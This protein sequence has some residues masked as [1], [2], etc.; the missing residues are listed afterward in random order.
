MKQVR[1]GFFAV[2]FCAGFVNAMSL[3][4]A[5]RLSLE[6]N[7]KT[8][9]NQLRVEAMQ[10][11][12]KAQWAS[13]YPALRLSSSVDMSNMDGLTTTS[14]GISVG[15]SVTI[16]NGGADKYEQKSLQA[17]L[18]AT[19]AR[20][21][22]S[23]ASMPN[24]KGSIAKNVKDAYVSLVDVI[25]QKK[26]L[27]ILS[28]TLQ[29][30][31]SAKPSDDEKLLIQQRLN[32]LN[33]SLIRTQA[34][35]ESALRDFR[36]FA[37]VP[38]P[39]LNQLDSYDQVTDSLDIPNS[40]DEAFQMALQ[41]SP[42]LK[43]AAYE[44]EAA[45]YDYKAE[46]ARLYAPKV[47]ANASIQRGTSVTNGFSSSVRTNSIGLSASF[48][49]SGASHYQDSAAAKNVAAS[50]RDR[51]GAIDELK[52]KIESIYPSL[53]TQEKLYE[54]QLQNLKSAQV[55]M[56]DIVRK[57][58][59]GQKVDLKTAMSVLDSQSQYW[60]SCVMQKKSILDTRFNIQRTIGTLFESLGL[61]K[62]A[63]TSIR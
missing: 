35:L 38:A 17:S 7:P 58:K 18:K 9:A 53:E 33:T 46:K 34:S 57:I 56:D 48:T 41:K 59:A 36:Y 4:E 22:S 25:E 1:L 61:P 54:S 3:Q 8:G 24:T 47:S 23:D 26:Y 27:D 13:L 10:D 49:I 19:D 29:I 62:E 51:D 39:D 20:Y 43:V 60:S 44:L 52:Y 31:M 11:R 15:T 21:S 28:Q 63:L 45:Q 42:D 6:N 2:L 30:F 12:A 55:S 32:N 37:T 14:H 50:M 40:A 16:Y 5:I